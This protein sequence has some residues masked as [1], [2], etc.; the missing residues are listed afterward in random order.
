VPCIYHHPSDVLE[1]AA[2]Q[3]GAYAL[4]VVT[5]IFGGAMRGRGA[6][7]CVAGGSD[8]GESGGGE[9]AGY[10]SNGCVDG[11][12]FFQ[13]RATIRAGSPRTLCYGEGAPYKDI[14]LPCGGRIDVLVMPNPPQEEIA[15][16][17]Q[18]LRARRSTRLRL[19]E[20]LFSYAPKIRLR[21]V[22]RG[23]A[24]LALATQAVHTGFEVI[25]QSPQED[26]IAGL[27]IPF[28]HLT[29]SSAVPALNDDQWSA[30]V[31]MFHDHEWEP[32]FL[33]Q[34]I[35]GPA[36]Y[37]GAMGSARTHALRKEIL[38][39][40]GGNAQDIARVR[41]PIGLI[42]TMRDA[43]LLALSILAEIVSEAQESGRL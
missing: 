34:A 21:I 3:S 1:F 14:K 23:E 18:D 20:L 8:G 13:A 25:V 28:E 30:V 19:G 17:V 40:R 22:G 27:D 7:M 12:I 29:V 10:I 15:L 37:I 42:P 41:G 24:V 33:L 43:N 38:R 35:K 9:I 36:F 32:E 26:I 4:V 2:K 39:E 16:A 6:L 11:D 5:K 31:L